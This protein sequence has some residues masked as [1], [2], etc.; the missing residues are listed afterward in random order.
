M[1]TPGFFT[2]STFFKF[3]FRIRLISIQRVKKNRSVYFRFRFAFWRFR[4]FR[5]FQV[6]C[7]SRVKLV[8]DNMK[9]FHDLY[10]LKD[11]HFKTILN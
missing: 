7:F 3:Y 2:T 8:N 5:F 10:R 11:F 1:L 9:S 6:L 4:V